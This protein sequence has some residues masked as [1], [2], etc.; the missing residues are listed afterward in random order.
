[1][2]TSVNCLIITKTIPYVSLSPCGPRLPMAAD[3]FPHPNLQP[4]TSRH[5]PHRHMSTPRPL[6]LPYPTLRRASFTSVL[7]LEHL[8]DFIYHA[9]TFYSGLLEEQTLRTFH[10]GWLEALGDLARCRMAITA[11]VTG[12][13]A[14]GPEALTMAAVSPV[15]SASPSP[16]VP[17]FSTPYHLS[18][19]SAKSSSTYEK[20]A[21]RIDDS[22]SV[23]LAAAKLL[24]VESE[25]ERW[26]CIVRDWYTRYQKAS[27]Y[28]F[29]ESR[30]G[31]RRTES[32]ISFHEDVSLNPATQILALIYIY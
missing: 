7:A 31:W 10:V 2:R 27:S 3:R 22:P 17:P 1:V 18:N 13:Q 28:W 20:P 32:H 14:A 15:L 30:E 5:H 19:M 23:G 24:D 11:M 9:Y 4:T 21:A 26:R 6:H 29:V 16:L 25:K 8:Q 12:T